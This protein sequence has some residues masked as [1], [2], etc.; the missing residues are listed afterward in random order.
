MKETISFRIESQ[1]REKLDQLVASTN[2]DRSALINDAIRA[3]LEFHSWFLGEV[4]RGLTEA[5]R[6]DFASPEEVA[7]TFKRL[8]HRV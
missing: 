2:T 5:N 4:E 8:T 1:N 7:A 6:G 3:Y